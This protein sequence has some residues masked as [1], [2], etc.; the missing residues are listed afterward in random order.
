[1]IPFETV[2]AIFAIAIETANISRYGKNFP[3]F[4]FFYL[5]PK[6]VSV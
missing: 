3:S 4:E 2:I 5:V 6:N 1:M